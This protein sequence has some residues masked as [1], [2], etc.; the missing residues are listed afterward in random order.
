MRKHRL[1]I[2]ALCT[3]LLAGIYMQSI[4]CTNVLVSKGAS[5]DGSVMI[6]YLADAGGFM[7]P[8][9]FYPG[10][11]Y[12]KGDSVDIYEWDTGNF[13]GR[14]PQVEKTYKVIG[15]MNEHQVAI[16]ETT[17]TGREELTDP[18]GIMDYGS[19]M[20][21][22]LQRSKTAREAIKVMTELAQEYGYASTGESFSIAD[23]N[24][25]WVMD[26]IGKGK[27][28]EGVVWA[29]ARVPDGYMAAHANQ[30][31]IRKIDWKD[32]ENWMWSEDI[33]DFAREM[34]WF[35]GKK[36]DFSF[37]DAYNPVDP[38][39]L[40]LCEG[41]VWSIFNRA[42]PS[43]EFSADYW[44]AVEGAE[45]YPLF[46]K[47]DKKITVEAMIALVRD[48]F[49][50]TPYYTGEGIAAGPYKVPYR[51]R[52]LFFELEDED[53][54]KQKYSWERTISQ[55]QTGFS[56]IS[57]SRNWLPDEIGGIFWY[58][59]DDTYSNAYMPLYMGMTRAPKSL[60]TGNVIDFDWD[61]AYWVF[62]LVANYAY[63]LYSFII[64]D[65][66][67]VQQEVETRAHKMTKAVDMA[68]QT[69]YETDKELAKEYLTDFSVSNAEYTVQRWR[70]LGH[71]I[72]SK[73]NDRYIRT[74]ESLRPWPTGVGYPEDFYK[75]AVEERPGYYDVKWRK[76]GEPI[77]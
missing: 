42:A 15:N 44:R 29:A 25:A 59:V 28:G 75:R 56:F 10:G 34:G 58:G 55:S 76:P 16:G 4:A 48:H 54:E 46:I 40:L 49:H 63:G 62:N 31:R 27:N 33:I 66:K 32:K 13:L 74:E 26:F 41:R 38:V 57:Q 71:H 17:F 51:W 1:S 19:L 52:S 60:T 30:A 50:D 24:E 3:V 68:A 6:S 64:E 22:A 35:D 67:E 11:N 73:Y 36:K 77:K 8:L 45:P 12:E 53:G 18:N 7:D 2:I 5:A 14:I 23:E 65:I 47:P 37:V 61:A 9:Y 39:S 69:L 21:I 43:Q 20:Y 70:E 72:F